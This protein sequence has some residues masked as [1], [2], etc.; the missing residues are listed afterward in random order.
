MNIVFCWSEMNGYMAAC[1]RQ[2]SEFAG[3]SV[4]IIAGAPGAFNIE[5]R[6]GREITEGLNTTLLSYND[7]MRN[8]GLV[9]DIVLGK[10]PD[11]IFI[12][13]WHCASFSALAFERKLSSAKF[14]MGFDTPRT[15]SLR[16][17][18]AWLKIGRL[19]RR[20]DMFVV[21]GERSWQFAVKLLRLPENKVRRGLYG[22]DYR[23]F[24]TALS[25][26]QN[27]RGNW[28][29]KFIFLGRHI[30]AKGIDILVQAY[31]KYRNLSPNPW[32]LTC[33]GTGHLRDL[34]IGVDGICDAGFVQPNDM[35][36]LLSQHGVFVL[37]SRHDPWPLALVEAAASG[38]PILC[39]N[40]CG[41]AIE[42]VR[43][44]YNGLLCAT[45][46]ADA[47]AQGLLWME[48]NYENL[49]AMGLRSQIAAEAYSADEWAR[50]W[51]DLIG[52]LLSVS[53][54]YRGEQ[55]AQE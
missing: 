18:L 13:G 2:L 12:P 31:R 29:R 6:Y 10:K 39:S 19:T 15:D 9:T 53:Q 21:P 46:D 36:D 3:I 8:D 49:P 14:I 50:R 34:T 48:C 4:A 35:P 24:S 20:M 37:A 28:P 45:S 26:R 54:E 23:R 25:K 7:L 51:N 1:W 47:L 11:V 16:Q 41:S 52:S 40:A 22:I 43:P 38:L 32:P 55:G 42:I 44:Q 17:R 5:N 33:C 27:L 30:E